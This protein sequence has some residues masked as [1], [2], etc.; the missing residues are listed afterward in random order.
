MKGKAHYGWR[1]DKN[2]R[3]RKKISIKATD[4][5]YLLQGGQ[6]YWPF[7]FTKDS[8]AKVIQP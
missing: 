6:P 3:F 7:P 2:S 5:Y 8:L 4:M 1:P